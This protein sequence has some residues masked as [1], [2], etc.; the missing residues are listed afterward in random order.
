MRSTSRDTL[1]WLQHVV[2]SLGDRRV[3]EVRAHGFEEF[4]LS[5]EQAFPRFERELAVRHGYRV[6]ER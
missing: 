1:G 6:T 5:A 4:V 2:F 3:L